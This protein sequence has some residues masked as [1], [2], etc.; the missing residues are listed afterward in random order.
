[1]CNPVYEKC[2]KVRSWVYGADHVT[3]KCGKT[4]SKALQYCAK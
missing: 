4:L 3:F 2:G 1:M